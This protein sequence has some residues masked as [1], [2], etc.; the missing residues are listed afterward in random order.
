M[1]RE[2]PQGNEVTLISFLSTVRILPKDSSGR[3]KN[4]EFFDDILL[5]SKL[6]IIID[7][8]LWIFTLFMYDSVIIFFSHDF[9]KNSKDSFFEVEKI[10]VSVFVIFSIPL[11]FFWGSLILYKKRMKRLHATL[12]YLDII[13][14]TNFAF[15][16]L[17]IA[18][19]YFLVALI[20]DFQF[21]ILVM[22]T[23]TAFTF[24]CYFATHFFTITIIDYS[25][26]VKDSLFSYYEFP[27]RSFDIFSIYFLGIFFP[28]SFS[29]NIN[30]QSLGTIGSVYMLIYG[31]YLLYATINKPKFTTML[32][33]F[34]LIKYS[35]DC[36]LSPILLVSTIW[37]NI[38]NIIFCAID[39]II[40]NL[41][42]SFIS[43]FLVLRSYEFSKNRLISPAT[44]GTTKITT[45]SAAVSAIRFGISLNMPQCQSF[46]FLKFIAN[47]RFCAD[48]VP[49]LIR[50]VYV[51]R[52]PLDE[53]IVPE[54]PLNS[55]SLVKLAFLAY[56][57]DK[58]FLSL[59]IPK[60]TA[61]AK[62]IM[63]KKQKFI[64]KLQSKVYIAKSSIQ[65]IW[66]N[67][68][69]CLE[70][71]DVLKHTQNELEDAICSDPLDLEIRQ[72]YETFSYEIL[73]T[74][75]K[76]PC[77][78][79]YRD[80]NRPYYNLLN[81][82]NNQ[83]EINSNNEININ[84]EVNMNLNEINLNNDINSEPS[85]NV[86]N[87][88]NNDAN[89]QKIG[90]FENNTEKNNKNHNIFINSKDLQNSMNEIRKF[91][92]IELKKER[93]NFDVFMKSLIHEHKL[94]FVMFYFLFFIALLIIT[95]IYGTIISF[96]SKEQANRFINITNFVNIQTELANE[97]LS[98]IEPHVYF[99]SPRRTQRLLG[100][101]EETT[102]TYLSRRI[103]PRT[104]LS[105]LSGLFL[106]MGNLSQPPILTI[107]ENLTCKNI[108]F[109]L[110][111]KHV[112]DPEASSDEIF[113]KISLI[114]YY[115]SQIALL[116]NDI[117]STFTEDLQANQTDVFT[118][119]ISFVSVSTVLFIILLIFEL[120]KQ[121][122]IIKC[123][124]NILSF[125][126]NLN[127]P[128]SSD[129][130]ANHI[131]AT[132]TN[133]VTNS[134]NNTNANNNVS[135]N[136]MSSSANSSV[137]ANSRVNANVNMIN[138]NYVSTTKSSDNLL[139]LDKGSDNQFEEERCF[140][141]DNDVFI[142]NSKFEIRK[143][144]IFMIFVWIVIIILTFL[145][146]S[147]YYYPSENNYHQMIT[148]LKQIAIVS[149]ISRS[150]QD[151]LTYSASFYTQSNFTIPVLK[152]I[153]NSSQEI[154][155]QIDF[156]KEIGIE[157]LFAHIP[158]LDRWNDLANSSYSAMLIDYAHLLM[159]GQVDA[160]Q[161]YYARYLYLFQIL[162]LLTST[163]PQMTTVAINAIKVISFLYLISIIIIIIIIGF[164]I[165]LMIY[166]QHRKH[167][168]FWAASIL[169]KRSIQESPEKL[170][171]LIREFNSKTEKEVFLDELPFALIVRNNNRILYTNDKA[172]L[173]T[174]AT[175]AQLCGQLYTDFFN[176]QINYES[177]LESENINLNN[178][179]NLEYLVKEF[180]NKH[181][182]N[183]IDKFDS[184][185]IKEIQDSK[186]INDDYLS[187]QNRMLP[188]TSL[189]LSFPYKNDFIVVKIRVNSELPGCE[190]IFEALNEDEHNFLYRVECGISFYTAI[191]PFE[192]TAEIVN[193][194]ENV[195][196]VGEGKAIFSIVYGTCTLIRPRNSIQILICGIAEKRGSECLVGLR[197]GILYI[198]QS[199]FERINKADLPEDWLVISPLLS[200]S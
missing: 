157:K 71:A 80:F 4:F 188:C 28:F 43:C 25:L 61:E 1:P 51:T 92:I 171:F 173:H 197:W 12:L 104:A 21:S 130:S 175:V 97:K 58:H 161:F 87:H 48:L 72:L 143:L 155:S 3:I 120:T 46:D 199:V 75:P 124:A 193:F 52:W 14:I 195:K 26:F 183:D 53:I 91:D 69:S 159:D 49:E 86:N 79:K 151:A 77:K 170:G 17:G 84:Q 118:I 101:D 185:I 32:G 169:M 10:G 44:T 168:W 172:C 100:I 9:K 192:K 114:N 187:F 40:M 174:S 131:N 85:R 19:G 179:S 117:I 134:A 152:F 22:A 7:T 126:P 57:V 119:Q 160:F 167:L 94:F 166:L 64:E 122:K 190:S 34:I 129:N 90:G 13:H 29:R 165:V 55:Q 128:L 191:G 65:S 27:F 5:R 59:N 96:R 178:G 180:G 125:S 127:T 66:A 109:L 15:P 140:N 33:F 24:V 186:L 158:P 162:P 182:Q 60:N 37:A 141:Q 106:F 35:V 177:N 108:S 113:C 150:T 198:D 54:I 164:L 56:Q 68:T 115:S 163:I 36:L 99:L 88:V 135:I 18:T 31:V 23:L 63:K 189:N 45:G 83:N 116:A 149:G 103:S 136:N 39:S 142:L 41:I 81:Q 138:L 2:T 78:R 67:Q 70:L 16:S 112:H 111:L 147:V 133:S 102:T 95:G 50:I 153:S 139:L 105:N 110:L 73:K 144:T 184:V 156:F 176:K 194:I 6:P 93:T 107:E 132:A 76:T 196:S 8:I 121:H 146:Y 47:W 89:Q 82:I 181:N 123:I 20:D 137:N 11:L 154:I 62:K 200:G 98:S 145:L 148:L 74:L 42:S 30:L 38:D